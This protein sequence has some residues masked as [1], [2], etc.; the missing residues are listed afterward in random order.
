M[1][2]EDWE[3]PE[4]TRDI[5]FRARSLYEKIDFLLWYIEPGIQSFKL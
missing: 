1:S 3:D 4:W 5:S 2:L